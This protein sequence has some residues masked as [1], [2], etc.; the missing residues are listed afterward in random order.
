MESGLLFD[1]PAVVPDIPERRRL[2]KNVNSR[3]IA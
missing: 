3:V 2:Q 1:L